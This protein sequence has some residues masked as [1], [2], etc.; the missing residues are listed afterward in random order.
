M[1]QLADLFR[2]IRAGLG[3]GEADVTEFFAPEELVSTAI[4]VSAYAEIKR[5]AIAAHRTQIKGEP[6]GELSPEEVRAELGCE[7][8]HLP[9]TRRAPGEPLET[10]LFTGLR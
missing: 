1:P 6:Y 7:Y 8:Y 5:Q 4:D 2:G 3:L 9:G 10:D